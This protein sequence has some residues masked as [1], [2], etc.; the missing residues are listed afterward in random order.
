MTP[1]SIALNRFGLGARPGDRIGDPRGWL[2]DQLRRYEARPSAL[3]AMVSTREGAGLVASFKEQR[4]EKRQAKR[5]ERQMAR[6]DAASPGNVRAANATQSPERK[7]YGQDVGSFYLA[8]AGARLN[9]AL[10]TD[11][12]FT[13]RL[14]HFWSNHFAVGSRNAI[15]RALIGGYESEAIRPHILGNFRDLLRAAEQHPLMLFYLN[16]VNSIGPDSPVGVRRAKNDGMNENLAREILELHTLGV[17]SGYTQQDVVEFARALTG[18]TA[19]GLARTRLEGVPGTFGFDDE[20]HQP[21]ARTVLGKTYP[22]GGREQ[23]ER[24]LD[25]LA[26]RPATARHLATKLTRHFAGSPEPQAMVDRLAAA[27]TRSDGDLS[28]VYGALIASPEAWIER[29]LRF[30]TPWEWVIATMRAAG[31]R[32]VDN[33]TSI[34]LLGQLSQPTWR[35]PQPSGWDDIDASWAAPDALVRRVEAAE[36]M[37][38]A[39]SEP[40]DARRIAEAIFP[41]ALSPVSAQALSRAESPSQALALLFVSPEMM[42]R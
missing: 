2:S 18:W 32:Q 21:G 14:V 12:P 35:P 28:A 15:G 4:A 42:R 29:P 7:E 39:R 3:A 38:G 37:A 11:T 17:R 16:Q 22:E 24:I 13:E 30:R 19:P 9:A 34:S 23:G 33:L 26:S 27:Y 25:D 31:T 36:R 10:V 5:R 8:S 40:L 41:G 1:N 20:R 6:G